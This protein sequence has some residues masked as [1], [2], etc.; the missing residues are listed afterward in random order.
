MIQKDVRKLEKLL[1]FFSVLSLG[2]VIIFVEVSLYICT[3]NPFH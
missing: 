3:P 2:S 1:D